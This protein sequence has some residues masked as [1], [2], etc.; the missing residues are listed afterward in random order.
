MASSLSTRLVNGGADCALLTGVASSLCLGRPTCGRAAHVSTGAAG[1]NLRTWRCAAATPLPDSCPSLGQNGCGYRICHTRLQNPAQLIRRRTL[2]GGGYLSVSWSLVGP[3][4]W[5]ASL[6]EEAAPCGAS[7]EDS[8]DS[9]DDATWQERAHWRRYRMVLAYDGTD[10]AGWQ[11]QPGKPTVQR[12]V[13]EAIGRITSRKRNELY[14]ATAG[15][16]DAGVHARG[17]VVHFD[18]PSPITDLEGF[19]F[20]LNALLP[21]GI[22]IHEVAA[23]TRDFHARYSAVRK[24]YRYH[25]LNSPL[26]DPFRRHFC[27]HEPLKLDISSMERAAAH[28]TGTHDFAAFANT[29][30]IKE[31]NSI[32]TIFRFDLVHEED[33]DCSFYFEVEGTGFLYRQVRNM[34]GVLLQVGRGALPASA[35]PVLLETCSREQVALAGPAAGPEGLFLTYVEYPA[36]VLVPPLGAPPTSYGRYKSPRQR[37]AWSGPE[38]RGSQPRAMDPV[39]VSLKQLHIWLACLMCNFHFI[40]FI[41]NAEL[42]LAQ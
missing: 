18:M 39:P 2:P 1:L 22:R 42:Y 35:V 12:A 14:M 7:D 20:S 16:T 40:L 9:A 27:L 29:S 11:W 10:F 17:Q 23:V 31:R 28:L 24:T 32:R 37:S 33:H 34:V 26:L 4:T 21:F 13:E 38:S 25:I 36:D 30:P 41:G 5:K 6:A 15:R 3:G 8:V 19:H